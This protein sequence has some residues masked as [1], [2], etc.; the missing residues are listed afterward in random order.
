MR[1]TLPATLAAALASAAPLAA[2]EPVPVLTV[3]ASATVEATPDVAT[4]SA[5]VVTQAPDAAAA[6]AANSTRMTEVVAALRKAGVAERDI[7]TSQL[8]VQPQYRYREG[9]APLITG[10]QAMNSVSVRLRDMA[11]VGPVLDTLVK[12]GANSVSG[13]DFMVDK[14][15]PLLDA[16]RAQAVKAARARAELLAAAAGVQVVRVLSIREGASF[17]PEFR[18]MMR[19]MAMDSVAAAPPPPV[20][21][22][23][24]R[25]TAQVTVSFEIR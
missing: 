16:A 20:A 24:T 9:Q 1:I 14:P 8:S 2:A 22:G 7:Q 15:E 17:E 19:T 3:T 5:G 13:P 21:P 6:L 12:V 23:E 11:R 18:P 25:L 4:L 10:Y